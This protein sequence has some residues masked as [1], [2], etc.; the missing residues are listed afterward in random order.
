VYDNLRERLKYKRRDLTLKSGRII[1]ADFE[2]AVYC[3]QDHE[4]PDEAL[5]V[6]ELTK[7]K[8]T[9]LENEG[10]NEVFD[11]RFSEV[12]FEFPSEF[13][14]AELIDQIEEAD[15]DDCKI[16]YDKSAS[17]C[18]L[19]FE[20]SNFRVRVRGSELVVTSTVKKSPKELIQGFF[21]IQKSLGS[22]VLVPALNG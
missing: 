16:D 2:Y 17:W 20:K 5:I 21:E 22:T 19:S 4:N 9:M 11:G 13:E 1:G 3:K 14:V 10:F 6:E 12:V 18:E 7:I 15:R 8:P